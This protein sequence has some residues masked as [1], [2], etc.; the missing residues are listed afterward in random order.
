MFYVQCVLRAFLICSLCRNLA[1]HGLLDI[2]FLDNG[3]F[4]PLY[5]LTIYTAVQ[6]RIT[7]FLSSY[8]NTSE[9]QDPKKVQKTEVESKVGFKYLRELPS[10]FDV[11]NHR[12][13]KS[14]TVFHVLSWTT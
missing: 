5:R 14:P 6:I 11:H 12:V 2:F 13:Q 1:N 10:E 9:R 4:Q 8:Q 7:R 3:K